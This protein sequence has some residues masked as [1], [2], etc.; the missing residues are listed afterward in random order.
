VG[1]NLFL[2]ATRFGKPLPLLYRS[3]LPFLV[4]MSVSVLIITYVPSLST[5][6]LDRWEGSHG[7]ESA[8]AILNDSAIDQGD[9]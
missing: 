1:L 9:P 6:V 7:A 4:I 8:P 3:A 2:S 5:G